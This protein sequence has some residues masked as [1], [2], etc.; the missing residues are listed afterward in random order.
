MVLGNI[1]LKIRLLSLLTSFMLVACVKADV[2][3]DSEKCIVSKGKQSIKL[4]LAAPCSLVKADNKGH[5]FFLYE[6]IRVYIIAGAPASIDELSRWSVKAED[7]CTLQ[8]QAIFISDNKLTSST[9]RD[10]GLTCPRI[11]LDEKIYLDFL[12]ESV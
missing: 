3:L 5:N 7:E 8:S 12:K 1:G 9:V 10:K 6:D 4:Q 2:K 11:G